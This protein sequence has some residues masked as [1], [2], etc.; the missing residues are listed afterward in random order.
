MALNSVQTY[1]E[2]CFGYM[3]CLVCIYNNRLDKLTQSLS[4][5]IQ[6]SDPIYQSIYDKHTNITV[7]YIA[8]S[9][10]QWGLVV[11]ADSTLMQVAR[12]QILVLASKTQFLV[13]ASKTK[14]VVG[15]RYQIEYT[16]E[17]VYKPRYHCSLWVSKKNPYGW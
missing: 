15:P 14:M 11:K 13:L 9:R 17:R 16:F 12:Y 6:Y 1:L 5:C 10:G 8:Q 4:R 2:S 7:L 3:L